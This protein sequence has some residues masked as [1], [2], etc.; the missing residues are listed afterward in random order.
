MTSTLTGSGWGVQGKNEMLLDA[1]GRRLGN[2]PEV[3]FLSF[4]INENWIC[5]M[6]RHHAQ[7]NIR[8][9]PSFNGT[10]ALFVG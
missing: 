8:L 3:Q 10:I 2:A 4:L 1:R 7:P 6:T 5:A 9:K